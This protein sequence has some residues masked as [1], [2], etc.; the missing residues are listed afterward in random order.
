MAGFSTFIIFTS[1]LCQIPVTAK[2]SGTLKE[3]VGALGG[4]VTFSLNFTEKQVHT[5]VWTFKTISFAI[6]VKDK[7]IVPQN[8]NKER[9]VFPDGSYSMTLSQLK[10][11]DSGV[12][13]A[14]I[15]STS[16]ESPFTQEYVLY[17]YEYLSR[18]KVTLNGQDNMNG[19]CTTNLTCSM[20]K[21]GEN[22]TY[23]WKAIGHGVN[24]S[25]DGAVLPISWR[26]GEKD[27][28]LI[29][30]AKNP[31]S[32]SSSIPTHIQ[33]LC[34]DAAKDL[35][36]SSI[37]LYILPVLIVLGLLLVIIPVAMHTEK[38]KVSKEDMEKVD[39]HQ[40]KPNFCPHLE[41]NPEYDTIPYMNETNM[42]EVAANTLYSTVQ[43]PK[44]VKSPNSLLAM[45]PTSR[46]LSFENI[47]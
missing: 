33:D 34:G 14:E 17:V 10:K 13:R 47:I 3:M 36:S 25:Y 4:S 45:P 19:T 11:N 21:G 44:V 22:V 42:E 26:L 2:T 12:Y 1:V 43:I 30:M 20:D 35:N 16:L 23:S 37:I 32:Q 46:P 38:G 15:H 29:C 18:P 24:E 40:E 7:V 41:E 28:T 31:I 8:H 27:K 6:I 9:I 39:I 5:I